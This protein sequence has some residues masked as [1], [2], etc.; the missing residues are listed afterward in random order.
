[1]EIV[2][3]N[4]QLSHHSQGICIPLN[5]QFLHLKYIQHYMQSYSLGR[6]QQILNITT[7]FRNMRGVSNSAES[8][9]VKSTRY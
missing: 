1:M 5:T 8:Q 6:I 2:Y 3:L 9:L 7:V 4:F